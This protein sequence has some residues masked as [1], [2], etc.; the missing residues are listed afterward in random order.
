MTAISQRVQGLAVDAGLTQTEV[1]RIVGTSVRTVARWAAGEVD[2]QPD[3]RDRLLKLN[4]VAKQLVD[5]LGLPPGDANVWLFEPN[6]LL[7]GDSPADRLTADDFRS[8]L[9]LIEALADGIVV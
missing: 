8:V 5:T 3:A 7:G 1:A 9:G 6:R 2:P 4:Y